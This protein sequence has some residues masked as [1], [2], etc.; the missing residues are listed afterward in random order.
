MRDLAEGYKKSGN[1]MD[2]QDKVE[3]LG[4]EYVLCLDNC[5]EPYPVK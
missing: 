2:Y 5:R 4:H 3:G 1:K